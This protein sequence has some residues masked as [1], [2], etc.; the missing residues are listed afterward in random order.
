M[1]VQKGYNRGVNFKL[2]GFNMKRFFRNCL[3]LSVLLTLVFACTSFAQNY[4]PFP[5]NDNL[6]EVFE[7]ISVTG[8][9][10]NTRVRL[11]TSNDEAWYCRWKM[12]EEAKS[13]IDCTYYIIDKDIFGQA[14]I[15]L[16]LKK[17]RAG[18]KIRLMI[19]GRVYRMPYMS[20][21]PDKIE[22]LAAFPNVEIKL[23]NSVRKSLA[24]AFTDFR[25]IAASNH[26]KI[27]ICDSKITIIGG[28]NIGAD[29]FSANGENDIV[30]N[31]CD[32]LMEGKHVA[33][34]LQKAFNDEWNYLKNSVV[35]ADILNFKN[36]ISVVE[37]A[38]RVM[39]RYIQ[40]RG[41]FDP[42]KTRVSETLKKN[43]TKM[44][45][46]IR[47][48]KNLTSYAAFDMFRGERFKPVKILDKHSRLG[49]LNGITP[50]LIKMI[51]ASKNE[52]IIQNPYLVITK[53]MEKALIRAS[54][55]GVEII[56]H[57]NSAGSTDSL[58][59]QAFLMNDWVRLLK[60][61]PTC[62]IYVAPSQN[63]RLHAKVFVFDGHIAVVGSYNM[64]PLSEEINSEVVA[65]INDKPFAQQTRLRIFK[66][67]SGNIIE[68]KI[69]LDERGNVIEKFGPEAHVS[70]KVIKKMNF[71]RKLQWLRPLI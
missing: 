23:Y 12:I 1:F 41:L 54:A 51:D 63:E 66:L 31:D 57:T 25:S 3:L 7:Q 47:K 22:E 9:F 52:I 11:V 44:N 4:R 17:A 30:Y 32:V 24:T 60:E 68:Y 58:F 5:N 36:Q 50:S 69:K 14:F 45:E 19:D 39:S 49:P 53:E 10:E 8:N 67:I 62:K 13:T 6:K 26:D 42:N 2:V 15:G 46:E 40:G 61:M 59:P 71:L 43:L 70:E 21:M 33:E 20:K 38:Y 35:K 48:Y 37:L 29:Y 28:R 34:Q 16:L 18:V 65:A 55:R 64:D 56:F 27:I